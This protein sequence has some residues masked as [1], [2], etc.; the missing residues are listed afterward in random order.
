MEVGNQILKFRKDFGMSQSD[1]ANIVGVSRQTVSNWESGKYS[2]DIVSL[3]ELSKVFNISVDQLIN[4]E[5]SR[6]KLVT[7]NRDDQVLARELKRLTVKFVMIYVN[8]LIAI[9]FESNLFLVFSTI[10]VFD[11]AVC[12]YKIRK[13]KR[14]YNL[15]GTESVLQFSENENNPYFD[16]SNFHDKHLNHTRMTLSRFIFT[17]VIVIITAMLTIRLLQVV[18]LNMIL[19]NI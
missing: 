3:N 16:P 5:I 8:A 9:L 18:P 10:S 6:Q 12:Y 11:T 19:P 2:P 1:L 14:K 15:K 13:I 4:G 17:V 7:I